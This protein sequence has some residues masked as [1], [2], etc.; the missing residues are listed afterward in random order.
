[1]NLTGNNIYF[2]QLSLC[3]T[4][5]SYLPLSSSSI[6]TRL[7][8]SDLFRKPFLS[9]FSNIKIMSLISCLGNYIFPNTIF[10]EVGTIK[11]NPFYDFM[12]FWNT[13]YT[14][15]FF[16][17]DLRLN[18]ILNLISTVSLTH[19]IITFLI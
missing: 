1:M 3:V 5:V 2:I 9:L 4:T 7:K 13:L 14:H 11:K 17:I 19:Y 16:S 10:A 8:C 18:E 15:I 12:L 6:P